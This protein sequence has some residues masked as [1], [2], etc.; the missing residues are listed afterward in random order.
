MQLGFGAV[1]MGFSMAEGP[2]TPVL[3]YEVEVP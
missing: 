1:T 3:K 2:F